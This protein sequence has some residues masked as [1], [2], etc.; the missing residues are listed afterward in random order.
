MRISL[1]VIDS[2]KPRLFIIW[3]CM[4]TVNRIG[5]GGN[6]NTNF[7]AWFAKLWAD[8]KWH[9]V[10]FCAT[11]DAHHINP[12]GQICRNDKTKVSIPIE[13]INFIL[14]KRDSTIMSRF[15]APVHFAS[16]PKRSCYRTRW[17]IHQLQIG[18]GWNS[19][20]SG[21]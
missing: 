18:T 1:P 9:G 19:K 10:I 17:R 6:Q 15:V 4:V 5:K 7:G 8:K 21:H 12:R 20:L 2:I 13:I 14:M 11:A 16:I 3:P